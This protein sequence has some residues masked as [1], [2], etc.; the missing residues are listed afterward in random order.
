M[1]ELLYDLNEDESKFPNRCPPPPKLFIKGLDAQG[2]D[3]S[4]IFVTSTIRHMIS[5]Y[6]TTV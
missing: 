5:L 1:N 3:S 6:S 2:K 4:Y